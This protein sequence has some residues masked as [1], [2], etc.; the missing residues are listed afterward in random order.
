VQELSG[1]MPTAN[2]LTGGMDEYFTRTDSV[3][4]WNFMTDA[5]GNTAALT[6]VTGTVQTQYTFDPF[7]NTTQ[8]GASSANSFAYTG[9][10][11][12]G[13]G[14][15]FLRARYYIPAI[16]RFISEDP[17]GLAGGINVYAYAYDNP[18]NF[19]DP[20]GLDVTINTY[21]GDFPN[22]FG[23][24]GIG[25]NSSSTWGF[26]ETCCRSSLI[27]D[28]DVP[29]KVVPDATEGDNLSN[30]D[31]TIT[32][33]TTPDQDALIQ[34]YIDRRHKDPGKFNLYGRQCTSFVREAL[35]AGGIPI[36][37]SCTRPECLMN[38]LKKT[39]SQPNALQDLE[40]LDYLENNPLP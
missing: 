8:G 10:E 18:V 34:A 3:G 37:D 23:H 7:G 20:S 28:R 24:I 33:S 27:L 21:H 12:D 2:L 31:E 39:Y 15:Y 16:G 38:Y 32:I 5:L 40:W 13:S 25:V 6:D 9:R 14:L 36:S 19:L 17:I 30:V 4:V 1:S 11:N 22:G 29:G 26:W 35:N